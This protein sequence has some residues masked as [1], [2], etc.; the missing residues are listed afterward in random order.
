MVCLQAECDDVARKVARELYGRPNHWFSTTCLHTYR[1]KINQTPEEEAFLNEMHCKHWSQM[2][3][4]VVATL[5]AT[6]RNVCHRSGVRFIEQPSKP[7]P[8]LRRTRHRRWQQTL[9]LRA[10]AWWRSRRTT[11]SPAGVEAH[12]SNDSTSNNNTEEGR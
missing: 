7:K 5:E 10:R 8:K 4:E 11:P 1:L 2:P 6:L 12:P 3:P 9:S